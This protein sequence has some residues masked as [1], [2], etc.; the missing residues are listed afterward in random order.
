MTTGINIF[1]LGW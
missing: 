1:D